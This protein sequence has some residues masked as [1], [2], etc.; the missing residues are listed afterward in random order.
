MLLIRSLLAL[1]G[2]ASL[3]SAEACS[4]ETLIKAR[5]KFFE[6][7]KSKGGAAE[8]GSA[9]VALNNK[10]VPLAQSPFGTLTGFS[11]LFVESVDVEKCDIATFRVSP[12]QVLSTRL[13]TT[14]AGA[15]T[16]VEF[17]QAVQGDQFFKPTGF[18]STTPELWASKQKPGKPPIIPTSWTPIG[19]TPGKDVHKA[20]CKSGVGEARLLNRTELVFIA[21]TYADG[22][23]GDP[24]GSCV[25]GHGTS[26]PRNENGVT[27]TTNCAGAQTGSFGF[28]TRGRRWVADPETGVVLGGFYFDYGGKGPGGRGS[29]AAG[30]SEAPGNPVVGGGGE[31][32]SK[33]FL[34]EYFKVEA[35]GLAAIYA[36]MKNIPGKQASASTFEGEKL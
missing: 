21:S 9:K 19:G 14:A 4:R 18:P 31:N 26:C 13:R 22:L 27:T 24:W 7:G 6:D 16:E 34:H 17:L 25:I 36:P 3:V 2:A 20:T 30:T 12:A 10:V 28:L 11:K 33:L 8:L 29:N 32:A 5:D 23:R 1:T 15:I 35:G